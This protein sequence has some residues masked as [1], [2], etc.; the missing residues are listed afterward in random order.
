MRTQRVSSRALRDGRYALELALATA[1]FVASLV[2][3]LRA[4][5][6]AVAV[7]HAKEVNDVLS[8]AATRLRAE[9]VAAG[10]DVRELVVAE[11]TDPKEQVD[12]A[13]LSPAPVA[14]IAIGEDE[15]AATLDVWV[16]DRATHE[17]VVRHLDA[18]GVSRKRAPAVLAVRAVE[19][20]RASL[21]EATERKKPV[22][23]PESNAGGEKKPAAGPAP[24]HDA[25]TKPARP[26][27]LL[28]FHGEVGVAMLYASP[29]ISAGFAPLLR[30]EYG[31]RTWAGR[32]TVVAPAFGAEAS[33]AG[34]SAALREEM[35]TLG[36][37]ARWPAE[38][39][40]ALVGSAEA[41]GYHLHVSGRGLSPNVG[42]DADQWGGVLEGGL[43][44]LVRFGPRSGLLL[45]TQAL[46]RL[47]PVVVQI[48]GTDAG[49]TGQPALCSSLGVW[50]AL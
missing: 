16:T 33:A 25:G 12:G 38:G 20:L 36:L 24:E 35:F 22:P 17:M 50:V 32:A 31:N 27:E 1:L 3:P 5:S 9:L 4:E 39:T 44:V 46:W 10:F 41:G 14:T 8:E 26:P 15:G 30:L 40:F 42:L 48:A 45:D 6:E 34:G 19:L 7:V 23:A 2:R 47:P 49:R 29:G 43:G 18:A 28:R 13:G 21:L 37:S 11:G